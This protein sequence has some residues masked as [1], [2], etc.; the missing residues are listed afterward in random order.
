[1]HTPYVL[2]RYLQSLGP[3]A[4]LAVLAVPVLIV[5]PLKLA[6]VFVLGNGHW[7][8]GLIAILCAYAVSL[9]VVERIF[10]IVEPKLLTLPWFAA[11]WS[12]FVMARAACVAWLGIDWRPGPKPYSRTPLEVEVRPRHGPPHVP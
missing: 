4:S 11:L 8:T 6:A 1:M 5:E 9:L 10:I 3:Y 2:R 12:R 7:I